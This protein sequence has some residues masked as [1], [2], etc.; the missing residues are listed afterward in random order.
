MV[1]KKFIFLASLLCLASIL[2]HLHAQ[3][4]NNKSWKAYIDAPINDTAILNIYADSSSITNVKG[5][6]M[7][8]HHCQISGDTLII[9]DATEDQGCANIKGSYK[10]S[11]TGKSFTLTPINDACAGRSQAL[12]GRKWTEV[13]EK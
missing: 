7:V 5:Q 1:M 13:I 11:L 9:V 10:I 8:R 12:V 4:I 3:S 2:C 6:V